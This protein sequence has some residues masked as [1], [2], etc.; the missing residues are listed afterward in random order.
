MAEESLREGPGEDVPGAGTAGGA[1]A[2]GEGSGSAAEGADGDLRRLLGRLGGFGLLLL[3]GWLLLTAVQVGLPYVRPGARIIVETKREWIRSA[4]LFPSDAR[5]RVAVFGD[6]RILSGFRP[7]LFDDLGGPGFSSFNLALP[8]SERY[9]DELTALCERGEVPTHVLLTVAWPVDP[10]RGFDVF[11]PLP[12][13]MET[14][15]RLVPFRDLPRNLT[16]FFLRSLSRGGPRAYYRA[17]EAII[18]SMLADRGWYFIE[19]QSHYP[20]HRLPEDFELESDT[21]DRIR[22]RRLDT[23]APAFRRLRAL[24]EEYGFEA[25]YV[26]V[27]FRQGA[28]APAAG[29]NAESTAV[30]AS[31]DGIGIVGPDY[32]LLPNR[33]FSDPVHVNPEGAEVYTR[34]LWELLEPVLGDGRET[35]R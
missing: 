28:Y 21:P 4:P 27:F 20:G 35:A 29:S 15:E 13:D 12:D 7:E 23:D 10:E 22:E 24:V 9:L 25:I 2:D 17:G 14:I 6:S 26:P 3:A 32:W 8:D 34:R 11:H 16:L 31:T 5:V 1:G 18:E 30:L 19:D 33:L